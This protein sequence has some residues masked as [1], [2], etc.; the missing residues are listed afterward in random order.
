M[1]SIILSEP[2]TNNK[3]SILGDLNDLVLNKSVDTIVT[4]SEMISNT[5]PSVE[6]T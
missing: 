3:I 6:R 2:K 4:H 5:V 1:S